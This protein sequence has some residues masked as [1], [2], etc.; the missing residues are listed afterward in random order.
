MPRDPHPIIAREGW[1][2]VAVALALAAA[3]SFSPWWP[4]A[5][6][7]WLVFLFV[8]QFFRDPPREVPASANAIVLRRRTAES[9]ASA[10]RAILI[11]SAMR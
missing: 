4:L 5:V 6:A 2:F 10:R 9:S 8:L 7:G 11:S 3:L 1:P